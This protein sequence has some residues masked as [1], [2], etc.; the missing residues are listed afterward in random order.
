MKGCKG[1]QKGH[2]INVGKK[3]TKEHKDKLASSISVTRKKLFES[4]ELEP[5][6][7]GKTNVYSEDT[8][9][10]MGKAQSI[11]QSGERNGMFGKTHTEETRKK[12]GELVRLRNT[13]LS[14]MNQEERKER[15]RKYY[16]EWKIKYRNENIQHRIAS[17]LRSRL[18]AVIK[19]NKKTGSAVKDLGCSVQELKDHL[20]SKFIEEMSWDNWGL[21]GRVWHI[22]HIIPLSSFDLTDREQ[23]LKACHYT[24]LQP[25]WAIDNI[26]KSN[27][28]LNT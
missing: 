4:G 24:N 14:Q 12:M 15:D 18:S 27:K 2:T 28:I 5:W 13:E 11:A 19:N 1:F 9:I 23:L 25:L 26:R 6:N 10:K 8:L 3:F 7:K 21:T 17:A 20:E 16:R 22:D